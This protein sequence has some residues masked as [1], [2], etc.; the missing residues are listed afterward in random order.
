MSAA[1]V[2]D[3][4]ALANKLKDS[5]EYNWF[6]GQLRAEW[7]PISSHAR[8][9]GGDVGAQK[10]YE[11]RISRFAAWAQSVPELSHLVEDER[12]VNEFFAILQHYGVPTCYIDFTTDPSVAGFFAS[13]CT[14]PPSEDGM[15]AIYCLNIEDIET[16]YAKLRLKNSE[17]VAELITIDVPNLWR[18][19]S[20]YGC[21]L[22]VN[23]DWTRFYKMDRI[24]FPWSGCP[25]YPT[26]EQIY[27]THKSGLEH[28]LDQYFAEERSR[29]GY[30]AF[31]AV[32]A[33]LEETGTRIPIAM[34]LESGPYDRS[35]F[36]A[37]LNVLSSWADE[38]RKEWTSLPSEDFHSTVGRQFP[39]KL[40]QGLGAPS[41]KNQ[42]VEA[43]RNIL[44]AQ[45]T[46]R[47]FAVDW[48][49]TGLPAGLESEHFSRCIRRAW[50]GM[51]RLPFTDQEIADAFGALVELCAKPACRSMLGSEIEEAFG[52]WL[53]DCL[54]VEFCPPNGASSRG[55][56][57][58][59][60]LLAALDE[61]FIKKLLDKSKASSAS[62]VLSVTYDP[63]LMFDFSSFS[64]I[65]ARELI[66]SQ[67]AAARELVLFNPAQLTTFGLP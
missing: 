7:S 59:A 60:G 55:F 56:C 26:S 11:Q 33:E 24:E 32:L 66:P 49:F 37:P 45:P 46:L 39:L 19:Q 35:A 58:S 13:D 15:C 3:A 42:T 38:I 50:N 1:N 36:V 30:E 28:L 6:R 53:P 40:R 47:Q 5:G 34:Q 4:I 22:Y 65:F 31:L 67:V 25:A 63:R 16:R 62:G 48:I 20:Q 21:F 57:S 27:P 17:T 54:E 8:K 51:R 10:A 61:Q 2:E 41:A 29:E 64:T 12:R 18:L 52:Q 14:E 9:I 44:R 43:V 23:H